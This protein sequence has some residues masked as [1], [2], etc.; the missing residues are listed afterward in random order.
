MDF[1]GEIIEHET[2][3]PKEPTPKPTL[4]G[5]P[6]LKKLKEKKV[7]RW[8]QKQ[9]QEQQQKTTSH[10]PTETRSE[11]SKIHQENIEKMAQMSE[12]EILQEREELLKGL[13]P[14]LIESLIGRSKKREGTGHGHNG[15]THEHAEGYHGWIGS[16]KTSEGLTDLSQLDKEDVDRALGISSLSLNESDGNNNSTKKVTFDDNIKTVK[17]EDLDEGIE[18]DPNGWEDVTDVNELVPNSDHIAPDDYQINPDSDDEG[19]NNTVHFTK[20]KQPE[21]DINDPDFFDKLHEKYYPDL[22]KETDKLS[23]MTQPMPKQVSTVYESIS[24]MRFD[25]KGDLIEL[26]AEGEESKGSSSDIPT[27][28]GLHHHSENPHMAGYTLGELAHLARSTLAGQRCLSIQTLGRILH[29]LGLHKYSILP[30]T[31]SGDPSFTDEIKQLSNSFEDM[32]WD[33]IDQLRIIE[34]ITEAADEKKTRNLSVRNYAIEAL[35]LYRTG[36]GRPETTKQT[37]EDLI[38]QAV[39]K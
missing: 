11:A 29:K 34:T 22:P 32:M 35:W 5:F 4:G 38:A 14:K 31:D 2:E 18:L 16:M 26:S 7:S 37:E 23:W 19:L 28:M 24:D 12:E 17:F 6:E 25:F 8:K 20:P 10:K 3:T 36:G 21:L 27:Y 33:L 9:Q 15:H 39:Q 13:D 30:T 1:I